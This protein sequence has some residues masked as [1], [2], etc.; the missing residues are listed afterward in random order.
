MAS[1]TPELLPPN[2]T[3]AA[4]ASGRDVLQTYLVIGVPAVVGLLLYPYILAN[5]GIVKFGI[6]SSLIAFGMFLATWDLGISLAI[7][8]E[9]ARL[10]AGEAAL[11]TRL[12]IVAAILIVVLISGALIAGVSIIDLVMP[13]DASF[14]GLSE[15]SNDYRN[16]LK[17]V[18][19]T[20]P[21][22]IATSIF[23]GA[24]DGVGNYS[25]ANLLKLSVVFCSFI[26]PA[27]FTFFTD[28]L[29]K[30]FL[31]V[32]V[33]RLVVFIYFSLDFRLASSVFSLVRI[34]SERVMVATYMRKL[35]TFGAWTFIAS[36]VG[37]AMI[38]GIIDR[39]FVG[40]I[41][42]A[43]LL[44][45]I[46]IPFDLLN[47]LALLPAALSVMVLG[48]LSIKNT[49]NFGNVKNNIKHCTAVYASQM[50]PITCIAIL[51]SEGVLRFLVGREDVDVVLLG[52]LLI[53]MLVGI[54]F[55]SLAQILAMLV[56]E[57]NDPHIAAYRH[58]I[59]V[60]FY[61]AVSFGIVSA[62]RLDL[63]GYAWCCL[64]VIDYLFLIAICHVRYQIEGFSRNILI[65][66]EFLIA[67]SIFSTAIIINIYEVSSLSFLLS[68]LCLA[69]LANSLLR[70]F[71]SKK[72]FSLKVDQ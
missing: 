45:V 43:D 72:P 33:A 47:R 21:F 14:R 52:T 28:S 32:F 61:V 15:N 42:D 26:L 18:L 19:V 60:P 29:T 3:I 38:T 9:L 48:F 4:E 55:N 31:G 68:F 6:F 70:I 51:N 13:E 30:I 67:L 1:Q 22:Q 12:H 57:R 63:I 46:A 49:H 66:R 59:Q 10:S 36:L 17:I 69:S 7:N 16:T 53:P 58:L 62:E 34:K 25:R 41:L 64:V 50:L 71:S 44:Y 39:F 11:D 40:H 5:L 37:G 65:S 35:T 24:Y 56:Y 23:R 27:A 54:Y 8:R 20:V 2:D